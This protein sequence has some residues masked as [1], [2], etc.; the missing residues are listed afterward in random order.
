ME[1]GPVEDMDL[2]VTLE[3]E[4]LAALTLVL[5]PL[6]DGGQRFERDCVGSWRKLRLVGSHK[7]C[8]RFKIA[9]V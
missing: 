8:G 7:E 3:I 6:C 1:T 4:T 2:A 9:P 5:T